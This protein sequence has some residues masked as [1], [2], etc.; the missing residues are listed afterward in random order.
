MLTLNWVYAQPWQRALLKLLRL[1]CGLLLLAPPVAALLIGS[2]IGELGRAA[3]HDGT[4]L[5]PAVYGW[6]CVAMGGIAFPV[7]TLCGQLRRHPPQ[8]LSETTTTID[9]AQELGRRPVGQGKHHWIAAQTWNNIFQV[10]F[11]TLTVAVPDL[12]PAWDGL[13]I[14]HLSDLHFCG[15]LEQDYYRWVL[16]RA[17]QDG[18]PDIVA[19]SGDIIDGEPYLA[20]IQPVLQELRW[21]GAAFAILGNHDWW[22]DHEGVRGRLAQL[23]MTVVGNQWTAHMVRGEPLVV[24]GHEGPW[25]R[26]APDLRGAPA[27]FRLLL[28]H[29]PDNINWARRHGVQLMLSGHNHGGQVRLPLIGS[30]FVPSKYSRRYDMGT[31]FRSPTLLHVNR[32]LGGKEPI[33]LRCRPQITRLI[34]RRGSA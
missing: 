12:P 19:L 17:L 5:V 4:N 10:D 30:L 28:S 9:V 2:D 11:T 7:A 16:R 21:N 23:G 13:S 1:L 32:G 3:L 6:L 20:W 14:L 33:R 34:L 8:V 24:V 18:V 25:F 31:F 29:T 22:Q 15:T 27:G 26:P